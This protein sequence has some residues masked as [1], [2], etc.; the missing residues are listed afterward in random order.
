MES[1]PWDDFL[2]IKDEVE[3]YRSLNEEVI[4]RLIDIED[5]GTWLPA[6]KGV[7]STNDNSP[8]SPVRT[9]RSPLICRGSQAIPTPTAYVY[10][11]GVDFI[12]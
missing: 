5:F 4:Q 9:A 7:F 3:G 11:Y 10:L 8:P 6:F 12:G 1:P 2:E